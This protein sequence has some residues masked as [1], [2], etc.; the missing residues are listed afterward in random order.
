MNDAT[1]ERLNQINREFY[2][3]TAE[4]FAE[5]RDQPWA[6]WDALLPTL[7]PPLTVLDVGCGNGRFGLF[8]AGKFGGATLT[9]VGLDNNLALLDRARVALDGIDARL[10]H[11]DILDNPPDTGEY[12][13]V[14]LFGVLHHIPGS[15][16]R[17]NLMRALATRVAPGGM[18]AFA[19]WQFY[20]YARFRDR[21]VPWPDDIE[22][23]RHDYL[24]DW[25]RGERALRYCHYVDDAEHADLIAATGL[26]EI[27]TYRADG[28]TNDI[29][30]YSLLRRESA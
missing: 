11:R 13:L 12:D 16:Q 1:I 23:E 29:N 18:L 6:G 14:G 8:L 10:E 4:D 27:A 9:Y 5:S 30:R 17:R 7:K 21:I 24:L 3:I 2:R 28:R 26:T 19:A 20:E 15:E 22:V 25:R